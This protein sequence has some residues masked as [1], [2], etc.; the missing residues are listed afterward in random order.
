[1]INRII[2]IQV[3]FLSNEGR[4]LLNAI[5]K[6]LKRDLDGLRNEDLMHH[7]LQAV[8]KILSFDAQKIDHTSL[9]NIDGCGQ[10]MY[11]AIEV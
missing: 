9:R 10:L 5:I 8:L 4:R 3:S 6:N 1:M 11:G 2:H 7:K